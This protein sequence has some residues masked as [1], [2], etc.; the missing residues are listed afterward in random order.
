MT[1]Y[2]HASEIKNYGFRF[3]GKNVLIS[4]KA[5]I[6]NP[7]EISIGDNSRIDDFCCISG[8]VKIGKNTHI[9][10]FCLIAGGAPGVIIGNYCTLAYRV[11]I[12]SQSDD[13]TGNSMVNST[14]P[15]VYKQEI[16]KRV[17]IEDHVI[18]GA[19][20]IVF[21]GVTIKEGSAIGALALVNK[22]TEAWSIN[23][24]IPSQFRRQ[25]SQKLLAIMERFLSN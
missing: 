5:S 18:I 25:R 12:F 7:E 11:S 16:K 8:Q 14:I 23:Y 20:A 22:A 21:P 6:Y 1:S 19:G 9:T 4:K 15:Q 10:P 3:V 24:G 2:M 17:V 13:Y